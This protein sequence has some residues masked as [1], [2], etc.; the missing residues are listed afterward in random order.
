M[1]L[2]TADILKRSG[3]DPA[4]V[5]NPRVTK[6]LAAELKRRG[7]R[8]VVVSVEGKRQGMWTNEVPLVSH[9]NAKAVMDSIMGP[10]DDKDEDDEVASRKWRPIDG[11]GG[12]M[13]GE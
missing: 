1:V 9:F 4:L 2:T 3:L 8:K 5:H 7:F 11:L 13:R 6:E 12:Q 10:G